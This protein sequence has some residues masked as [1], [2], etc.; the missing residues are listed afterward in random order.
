[1]RVYVVSCMFSIKQLIPNAGIQKKI[2]VF[3]YVKK[4]NES[5][6]NISIESNENSEILGKDFE[7]SLKNKLRVYG[8]NE[9]TSK[10]D[11]KLS[12]HRSYANDACV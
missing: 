5:K 9:K 8:N 12:P 7:K 2:N 3:L 1:M 6:S 11:E 4:E 10:D